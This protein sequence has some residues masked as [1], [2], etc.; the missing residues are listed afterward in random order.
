MRL[1]A[2]RFF[3]IYFLLQDQ[4]AFSINGKAVSLDIGSE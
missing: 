4:P 2:F 3:F 1:N